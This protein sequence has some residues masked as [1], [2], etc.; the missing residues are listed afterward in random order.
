VTETKA[1]PS[2][3]TDDSAASTIRVLLVDDHE[4]VRDGLRLLIGNEQGV[5]IC[6][7]AEDETSALRKVRKLKP[8]IVVVDL[9]LSGG[10]GLEL[11]KSIHKD[12]PQIKTIVSTMHDEN[13]YGERAL[14]AGARGYVNKHDPARTILK[15]IRQVLDGKMFFSDTLIQKLMQ[16]TAGRADASCAPMDTLS[17]R[18]LE[19][20]TFI[21][22]GVSTPQIA[23]KL[24][25]SPRT[26]E[27]YRERLKTKLNLASAIELNRQAVEWVVERR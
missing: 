14:R 22:Q 5:E 11:I 26:V 4:L 18:E 17:N 21:G 1:K 15:A 19:V 7:E 25:I 8:D 27:T 13:V 2:R 20:F 10:N 16:R 23:E 9:T 12:H 24:N 6:G 3:H